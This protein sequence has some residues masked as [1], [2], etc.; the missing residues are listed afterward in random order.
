MTEYRFYPEGTTPPVSTFAFHEHRERA[1]H[2]EQP[3]HAPRL[4]R[5][6]AF[7][8]E[9]AELW[10]AGGP[11]RDRPLPVR[12]S[13]LGCGDG[14]LLSLL[15]DV[16]DVDAWGYDFAPANAAG[17]TERGVQAEALDVFGTDRDRVR[18]GNIVVMTEVLEHVAD[19]HEVVR[20]VAANPGTEYLV[21]SSPWPET[22]ANHDEC[23]AWAWDLNGYRDLIEQGGFRVLRQEQEGWFQ[24]V[25]AWRP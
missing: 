5:A 4:L 9:A 23:H 2:L 13:D 19:P 7:V 18:L 22:P 21:A 1:A 14:G 3:G 11:M 24:V 17:W 6:R 8:A 16:P 15:R 12:V 10:R 20:W 25:L